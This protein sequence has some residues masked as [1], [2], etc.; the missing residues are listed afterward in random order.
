MSEHR[1]ASRYAKSL[2]DLASEQQAVEVI[3]N[4]MDLLLQTANNSLE[5]RN[6]LKSP[7]VNM[8]DKKAVLHKVF[9]S[10]F[11]KTSMAFMDIVVRKNRSNYLLQM[12]SAYLEQYNLLN[13]ITTATVKTAHPI[14]A[15]TAT[16]I[17]NFIQKQSGKKVSIQ[18][19][20][21]PELIGG[22]V[23]QMGDN[24]YDASIAGKLNKVKQQLLNTYI[25]K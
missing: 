2:I 23:I 18:A 12:A 11:H 24:L 20:V 14:D 5:L 25:S 7:V 17:S 10:K 22:V 4:D 13:G 9:E 19:T 3:K 8:D 15:A 21:D 16:E 1:I 6:M